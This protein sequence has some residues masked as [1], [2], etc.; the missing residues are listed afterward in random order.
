M[1]C[2]QTTFVTLNGFCQL[3]Q[4]PQPPPPPPPFPSLVLNGQNQDGQNTK[5]NQMKNTHPLYLA[6]E[7]LKV[8]LII[9]CETQPL[10]LLFL[11]VLC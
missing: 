9:S 4:L 5:Q 11:V 6:F 7:V 2:L 10:D 3:I 1:D 8:H